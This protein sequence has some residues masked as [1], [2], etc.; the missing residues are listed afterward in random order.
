M[1]QTS[2]FIAALLAVCLVF[3]ASAAFAQGGA[4]PKPMTV[5]EVWDLPANTPVVVEGYIIKDL[6]PGKYALSQSQEQGS[7]EIGVKI[8]DEAWGG[9]PTGE[10]DPVVVHGKTIKDGRLI[11]IEASS[12]E[13]K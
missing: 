10:K 8:S 11:E 13:R 9:K 12:I 6:G 2:Y 4:E 1:R 7:D 5:K 3:G